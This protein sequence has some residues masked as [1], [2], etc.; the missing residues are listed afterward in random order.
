[1]APLAGAM[2]AVVTRRFATLVL[3][4]LGA[5][6]A[7]FVLVHAYLVHSPAHA[8]AT[9]DARVTPALVA[10]AGPS[11]AESTRPVDPALRARAAAR[12]LVAAKRH[13][14]AKCWAPLL[15]RESDPPRSKHLVRETF[16]AAGKEQRRE[17]EDVP[18]SSRDDVGSCLKQL[19]LDLRIEPFGRPITVAVT[20][21]F[22]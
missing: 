15:A 11:A 19:P 5:A 12:A 10:A 7:A 22:P 1:V 9:A 20:L 2:D 16:D 6:A 21:A 18:G 13:F 3:S 14:A 8:V 4:S 17:V